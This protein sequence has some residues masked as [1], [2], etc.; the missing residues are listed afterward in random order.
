M[1]KQRNTS[2]Y[3]L[4]VTLCLILAAS[5]LFHTKT[6]QTEAAT[7]YKELWSSGFT[8][9]I[10]K[11]GKYYFKCVYA[12]GYSYV[13][14]STNKNSGYKITPL[15]SYSTFS[16]GKQAYYIKNNTL[17][18]YVFSTQKEVLLKKP[19]V[20]GD[21]YYMVSTV[22]GSQ[23]FLTKSSFDQWKFWTYSYNTKTGKLKLVKT[24]CKIN[25]RY[26]KYAVAQGAF[27]TDIAPYPLTIYKITAS[28]LSKVKKIS[29]YGR[30]EI[31]IKNK[32]YYAIYT[33]SMKKVT[34]Y[35]SK[36]NGSGAK[37]IATFS[38]SSQYGT[39]TVTKITSKYCEIFK[40]QYKSGKY[41]Q[42]TY[43]YT[44]ATKKLKKI[45]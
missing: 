44:Y 14:I 24:N 39:V 45:K 17:Y 26:G 13:Y 29:S 21:Q 19:S 25:A 32:L 5:F 6:L 27:R 41:T 20:S 2:L 16:N 28:G 18:R 38:V 9:T 11:S 37:K 31:F 10:E 1:K 30:D 4:I 33:K 43:R 34:L 8:N 42:A 40:H 15:P 36:P 22:Y 12:N 7:E 35:R 3:H 23:V